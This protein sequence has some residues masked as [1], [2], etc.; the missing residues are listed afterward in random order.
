MIVNYKSRKDGMS[1]RLTSALLHDLQVR[2]VVDDNDKKTNFVF[3]QKIWSTS[4]IVYMPVANDFV[5]L[6][7]KKANQF[8]ELFLD[9]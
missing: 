4:A 3:N 1:S 8:Q 2:I 6:G 7:K 5:V 9:T